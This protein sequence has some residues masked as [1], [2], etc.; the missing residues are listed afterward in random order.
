MT[1]HKRGVRKALS[2]SFI[3][4]FISLVFSIASVTIVSRLLTP[5]QIGVFSVAVGLV[6]LVHM[7]RDFGV[8]EFVI[9]E[10]IIDEDMIRT[11]FTVNLV[12]AW[13]LAVILFVCSGAIGRF[14]D[15]PGVARVTKV[16]SLIF[17]VFPFG[18]VTQALMK[19]DLEF[20][21]LLKVRMGETVTRSSLTV[22]LAYAGFT[23][24]SMAWASLAA[25]CVTVIGC[26]IW[27]WEYR[28][29]GLS[30]AKWKRV[31]KFGMNRTI[32][33]IVVQIG[34]QSPNIIVGKML[35]MGDAGF[36]SRG[37]GIV[38]I[39]R[40]NVIGAV[41]AVAFPAYARDHRET[42]T[43]PELFL[44]SLVYLTG[45]SWPFFAFAAIMAYPIIHVMF[46]NQWDTAVPLMRWLCGAAVVGTLVYQCNGLF[47]A[48]GRY[49]EVTSVE[50]QF[51]LSRVALVIMAVFYGLQ[52]VAASQVLVY[53]IAVVLYYR[54]LVKYDALKISKIITALLPSGVITVTSCVVPAAV[55]VLW[56]GSVSRHVVPALVVAAAGAGAG[57]L[58]GVV[59]TRHP[60]LFEIKHVLSSFN[61]RL[62]SLP[63]VR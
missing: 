55:F 14:F 4:T 10:N 43:A 29:R 49:R 63:G 12:I 31:L 34:T 33:D 41:G 48:V 25:I 36:Y 47:T 61:S 28:V 16:L 7:L 8:S 1:K 35:G 45:I 20:G 51:Q 54:K 11:A 39:F 60:L 6:A 62:R 59:L 30:L 5:A 26:T 17:V 18:T 19:R 13:C 44:R 37:Y 22:G 40:T 21:K 2:L 58:L 3:Q 53:V 27:G 38:N 56:P 32:S 46:G 50:I 42:N 24:M 9:Q 52:A 23:Y 15:D 57:W